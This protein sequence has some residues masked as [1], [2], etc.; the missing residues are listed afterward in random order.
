MVQA[1][2]GMP[3]PCVGRYL[4]GILA[5]LAF[6]GAPRRLQG[7]PRRLPKASRRLQDASRRLQNG[8]KNFQDAFKPRSARQK[9]CAYLMGFKAFAILAFASDI[10]VEFHSTWLA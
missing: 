6:K 9:S 10:L 5:H 1:G 2:W 3:G 8:T 7:R 4:G